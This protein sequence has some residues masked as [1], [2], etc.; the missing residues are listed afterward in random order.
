MARAAWNSISS[1]TIKHCWDHTQIQPDPSTL[2]QA[3]SNPLPHA[4]LDA[5]RVIRDFAT[6]EMSLPEAEKRVE[7]ILGTRYADTNWR[8]TFKAMMDAEGDSDA[9]ASTVEQLT[10]AACQQ[11]AIENEVTTSLQDLRARNHIFGEPPSLDKFLKPAEEQ[12][13]GDSLE[14]EGRDKAIVAAVKQEMAEKAGEVIEVS[15]EEED[16]EPEVSHAETLVLCQWLEGAS[17]QVGN[18]ESPFPLE[19]LKQIRLFSH[20]VTTLMSFFMEHKP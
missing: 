14:F 3:P 8:P 10:Q 2:S 4:D 5:W 6:T 18:A 20:S 9:A 17:L 15:D 16:P 7:K 1:T 12:E 13:V 11:T 19:L